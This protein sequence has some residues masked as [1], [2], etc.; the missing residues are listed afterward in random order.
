MA[1]ELILD[2][3]FSEVIT[4]KDTCNFEF[5]V[6]CAIHYPSKRFDLHFAIIPLPG[7]VATLEGF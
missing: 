6:K 3:N 1:Q 4:L 7:V 2:P 5:L